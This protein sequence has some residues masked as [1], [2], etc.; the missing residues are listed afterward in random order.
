[1]HPNGG[2]IDTATV[3]DFILHGLT[4]GLKI[5]FSA[6]PPP[7]LW[8]GWPSFFVSLVF[9]GGLALI[10]GYYE[11]T[12]FYSQCI[13]CRDLARIFGCLIGL[14]DEVTA[15]TIVTL[16]TSLIDVFATMKAAVMDP[17]AD[18]SLG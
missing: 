16:G 3:T 5:L 15:I 12:L 6:C 7:G 18:N 10:I 1:M 17:A 8:R 13:L 4:F 14:K 11:M 9:I 2:K